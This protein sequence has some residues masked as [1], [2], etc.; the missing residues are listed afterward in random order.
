[1]YYEDWY[2]NNLGAC[3]LISEL[4]VC[5][6]FLSISCN[7]YKL[8]QCFSFMLVFVIHIVLS[9]VV[10]LTFVSYHVL[11][12]TCMFY[13]YIYIYICACHNSVHITVE[14][15]KELWTLNFLIAI[16]ALNQSTAVNRRPSQCSY[17][18]IWGK[19]QFYSKTIYPRNLESTLL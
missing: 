10:C 13:L 9:H 15:I 3:V 4:K 17:Q 1:M 8:Y 19:L 18:I 12:Y 14:T 2:Y 11:L 5:I 16:N 6:N 7:V